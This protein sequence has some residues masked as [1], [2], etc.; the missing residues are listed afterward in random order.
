M[1]IDPYFCTKLQTVNA[2]NRAGKEH[3]CKSTELLNLVHARSLRKH[4]QINK[5]SG[6][7]KNLITTQPANINSMDCVKS[8]LFL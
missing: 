7:K 8:G 2:T 5:A 4:K 3:K 1:T 6:E